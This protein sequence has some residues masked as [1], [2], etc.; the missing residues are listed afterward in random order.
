MLDVFLPTLEYEKPLV[1]TLR[2]ETKQTMGRPRPPLPKLHRFCVVSFAFTRL[3]AGALDPGE[4]RGEGC[5][6]V[7]GVEAVQV[8][9]GL[10]QLVPAKWAWSGGNYWLI[11]GI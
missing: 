4:R 10:L 9:D 6:R 11:D 8:A 7:G 5:A 2:V 3:R 1:F